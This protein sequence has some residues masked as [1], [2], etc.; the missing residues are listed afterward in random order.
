[1]RV[2]KGY[3][4]HTGYAGNCPSNWDIIITHSGAIIFEAETVKQTHL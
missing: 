1:M 3:M 4:L 2:A